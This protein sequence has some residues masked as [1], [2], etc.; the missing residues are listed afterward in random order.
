MAYVSTDATHFTA[1][2]TGV[3]PD[4]NFHQWRI[5]ADGSG[6][7]NFYIDNALV[8]SI[9]TGATGMPTSTTT[10]AWTLGLDGAGTVNIYLNSMQW[11]SVY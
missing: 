5:V 10:M 11:W 9:A 1:V 7:W 2:S 6:G 8:A 3:T 4:A